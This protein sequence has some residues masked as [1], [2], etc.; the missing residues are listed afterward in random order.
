MPPKLAK[1][2]RTVL[3]AR[4]RS[5]HQAWL[6][7]RPNTKGDNR[8]WNLLFNEDLSRP[9][10]GFAKRWA[11]CC[12]CRVSHNFTSRWTPNHQKRSMTPEK[13]PI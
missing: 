4:L 9:H 12:G 1:E 3:G 11:R 13:P 8:T 10:T 6:D 7:G 2:F 5:S